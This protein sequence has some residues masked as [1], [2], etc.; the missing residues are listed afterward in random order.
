[1]RDRVLAVARHLWP[2]ALYVR[3]VWFLVRTGDGNRREEEAT[4]R[5]VLDELVD[6]GHYVKRETQWKGR[7]YRTVY[8]P[9]T[10]EK[11]S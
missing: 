3:Q 5:A 2:T 10:K 7:S 1:M 9:V 6:A 4:V 8:V 11:R